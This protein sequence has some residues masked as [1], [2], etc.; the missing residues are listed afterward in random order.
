MSLLSILGGLGA[1]GSLA[2]GIGAS[3]AASQA[4]AAQGEQIGLLKKAQKYQFKRQAQIDPIF[5]GLLSQALTRTHGVPKMAGAYGPGLLPS[6]A[7]HA[8]V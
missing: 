8:C 1:L 5:L 4:G 3:N 6:S 7:R 2:G